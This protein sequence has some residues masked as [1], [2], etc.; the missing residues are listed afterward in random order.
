MKSCFFIGYRDAPEGIMPSLAEAVE[1]HIAEFGVCEFV[2]GHYG[3]FD[4]MAARAVICAKQKH[5]EVRLYLLLPYHPAE[6]PVE[7]PPGFDGAFY[8]PGMENV[9]HRFAIDR[10]NR[11]MID[12]TDYLIAY[13]WK[14]GSNAR[15]LA[16]YAISKK[17][18]GHICVTNLYSR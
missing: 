9:P 6:R 11:Y 12:H 10:A 16:G 3:A 14:P 5:P 17:K 15:N 18:N 2:V 13:A 1:Q 7:L 8:P 4:R